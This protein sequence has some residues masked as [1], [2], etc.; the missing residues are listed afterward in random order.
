MVVY[1]IW[2][3]YVVLLYIVL[4]FKQKTAYEMLISDW[5]SDVCS[6]DLCLHSGSLLRPHEKRADGGELCLAN[7]NGRGG[8]QSG[9]ISSEKSRTPRKLV[10]RAIVSQGRKQPQQGLVAPGRW[11]L[12]R[13]FLSK[14]SLQFL[15]RRG[16]GHGRH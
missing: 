3:C 14:F 12:G 2:C 15:R 4:F 8:S 16:R 10:H 6:S 13:G 7:G 9:G 11:R 1:M 5:S